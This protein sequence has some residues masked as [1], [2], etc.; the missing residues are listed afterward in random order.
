[1]I[2]RDQNQTSKDL[3]SMFDDACTVG[4]MGEVKKAK[5]LKGLKD[6]YLDFF[7]SNI[8]AITS[9]IR[10][11]R[12]M[13]QAAINQYREKIPSQYPLSP[14]WRIKGLICYGP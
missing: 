13:R 11:N 3:R 12:N 8:S 10:G 9:S 2:P 7:I 14:V 6:T 1:M 4:R 5:T